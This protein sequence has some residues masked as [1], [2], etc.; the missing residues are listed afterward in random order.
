ME[1]ASPAA[2]MRW[3]ITTASPTVPR[4]INTPMI[5]TSHLSA[6]TP[7][8][9]D[10]APQPDLR[11][12]VAPPEAAGTRADR[13]LA[14]A[15]DGLSRSRVKALIEAGQASRDGQSLTDPAE[16]VRALSLIHI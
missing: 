5:P 9:A 4:T 6:A 15:L 7:S 10:P 1:A 14:D 12:V 13:F 3:T 16:S 2:P 8:P 11:E